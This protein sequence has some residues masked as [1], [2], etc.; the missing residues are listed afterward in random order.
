M[1]KERKTHLTVFFAT[2]AVFVIMVAAFTQD[3][4]KGTTL[5]LDLQGGFEIVYQV[6]PLK[7]GQSLPDMMAVTRSISKRIDVLGVA[8]P[9]II[10]EGNDRVRIQLAGISDQ[11]QAR[12]MISATANLTFRDIQDNLLADGTIISEGGASL[13][14][15]NGVPV[16]SL[17][18]ADQAKFAEITKN[19]A[20]LGNGGNLIVT[21][22]DFEE[23]IDSYSAEAAKVAN[24]EVP[25]YISVAGVSSQITGD[26]I[27]KGNFTDKEARELADL[28]NSGSLPVK[29]DEVYSNVVSAEYGID[30]FNST[31]LAGIVG[32]VLVIVFMIALYRVLGIIT[33]GI[34]I[35]Y[36]F[37]TFAIYNAMGGVFTLPGIAALV[38]GVGMTVDSNIITY[39]RIKD[40]LYRGRSVL[41][42]V[43]GGQSSSFVTIFDAQF[44]TFLAALIMYIFGTGTV[45]GFATM[46]MVTL[47]CTMLFNIGISRF[48][49]LQ[50]AKSGILDDRKSWLGVK[51]DC[52]PD[53]SKKQ[54]QFYF[55]PIHGVDY[56][57]KSKFVLMISAVV[58]AGAIIMMSINGTQ[59]K[60]IVNLGIDFSSGTKITVTSASAINI[61]EVAVEF[62][63]LGYDPSQ[64]Q[65][66]GDRSVHVTIKEALNHEQL[67]KIKD[68]F[69]EKYGIEPNDNV[70][71]PTVGAEL[72]KDAIYLTLLAWV[73]ML[74]YI[75]FR[76]KWDFAVA[77]IV[78]L[79]HDV[80]IVLAIF[81][82]FRF[83]FTI[84]LI[85]VCLA[86]IGYSI[87]NAI[88]VFDRI[89]EL[90]E[91]KKGSKLDFAGYKKI[92]NEALNFTALRSLTSSIST[93]L[94]VVALLALGS[95]AIFTF[96]FAM[97]IGLV[98]GALSSI[99][100]APYVW[101]QIRSRMKPKQKKKK[102]QKKEKLDEMTI[103]GI[104][105]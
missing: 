17:K 62:D 50:L 66:S 27:I 73:A 71:T 58:F 76:F 92:V 69:V 100:I 15:E 51:E 59:G 61:D 25:K 12:R 101:L 81:A 19:L 75:T 31:V 83:E 98:S 26:A 22:L 24:G 38:L 53:V 44:T 20:G 37:A 64:V 21:W 52:I 42:A 77:C 84:E 95:N 45:K 10:I 104:N 43:R 7:E 90:L 46:L 91:D 55:G 99:F 23:G 48:L 35:L 4:M 78:A 54:E 47:I 34:L 36:I 33:S 18:I 39:E 11:E 57:S 3:I 41:S 6:S 87:D 8:E 70:V 49:L 67:D 88:V 82:L 30:A 79:M 14:F 1:N 40:E 5:G 93:L 60:G 74:L 72:I 102:K 96:N 97:F 86:I 32:V 85:S 56:L 94:P 65:L 68:V 63:K 103:L 80:L 29:M 89:R 2:L 13:G 16:V 9:Q 28:I 105:A